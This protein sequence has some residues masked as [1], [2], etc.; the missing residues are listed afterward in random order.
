MLF[1]IIVAAWVMFNVLV[2]TPANAFVFSALLG[3]IGGALAQFGI[4]TPLIGLGSIGA[5]NAGFA[6]AGFLASGFGSILLSAGVTALRAVLGGRRGGQQQAPSVE[7]AKVNVRIPEPERWLHFGLS[8]S[9]GGVV[10][11]EFDDVGAFWYIVI[12]GDSELLATTQVYFDDRPITID[13]GNNVTTDEFCLNDEKNQYEGTGTKVT[14]FQVW[15][16]TFTVGNP[17]PPAIAAF[18]AKFSQWT[19]EHV[20][21]GTCFSVVRCAPLEA[22]NRYKVFRWRGPFGLGE[23]AVSV[24]GQWERCYDPREVGHDIDDP[25]TWEF[26]RNPVLIWARYRTH[27]YGRNKPMSSIN[28][29]KV[30]EQADICDQDVTGINGTVKRYQC[31]ISI[32]ESKERHIGE[33]EILLSCDGMVLYDSEGKAYPSVGYYE[34]PDLTLT[35]SRDIMAMA[36]REAVNGESET[37]GVIVR[38]IDPDLNY[39]PQPAAAWVNPIYYVEGTTPRY[40]KIDVLSCQNHN[41]AMRLAKAYGLRSQ[42]SH[43]LVPTAGLRALRARQRRIVDIQYDA[44]FS[45]DYEIATPV[46]V[47]ASGVAVQ[48][49][50]VPVDANRWTLLEGEEQSQPVIPDPIPSSGAP[51]LPTGVT[52]Y[53]APVEGSGGSAVRIEAT[54]DPSPRPDHRYEFYYRIQGDTIWRPMVVRMEDQIAYSDTVPNGQTHSVRWRT[55][56]SSARATAYIDPIVSIEAVA[57]TTPPGAVSGVSAT[58]GAGSIEFEWTNPN[59]GNF[60]AARIYLHTANDFGAATLIHVEYGAPNVADSYEHTGLTA[61]TYYGFVESINGSAVASSPV[62]T[63]SITVT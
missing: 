30:G 19:D 52:V 25:S 51:V 57:D 50:C 13:G 34:A 38:Y 5:V 46:E 39:T 41:Q 63:G 54:F 17:V 40:L 56:T 20:L 2:P 35:R 28:W 37:D 24:V 14:Y 44:T 62:A 1:R 6:V 9:G 7:A 58:G 21:A 53:A 15:T 61:G 48:F 59:S 23:P 26:S 16:T 36:S 11:G 4:I 49:G 32:P 27:P 29:A 22:E 8:R 60:L 31:G 18:K 10:F 42:S 12:H 45:G 33:A 55:V 3:A 47:D 43:R